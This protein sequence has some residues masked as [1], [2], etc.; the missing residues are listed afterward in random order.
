MTSIGTTDTREAQRAVFGQQLERTGWALFLIM[1]GGLALLPAGTLPEGTWLVGT[2]LIM[3]GLNVV[4]HIKGIRMNGFANVLGVAAVAAGTS[5]ISG[6]E[7]PVLPL[8][9]AAIGLQMICSL[10]FS[11]R[12]TR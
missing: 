6:V 10:V 5:S 3:I 12:G 2:G 11:G 7:L 1:I 9:L 4:R 8:L